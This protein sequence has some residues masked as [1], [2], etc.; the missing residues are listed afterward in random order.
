MPHLHI[1]EP[2]QAM[3]ALAEVY[4]RMGSRP[5]PQIYRPAHGGIAG[6]VRAHSLDPG[7]MPKAFGFSGGVNQAGPLTWPHRELVAAATSRLNQC[8]Y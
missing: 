3:G 1:I 4:E 7:L 2:A 5:M 6:I 8:F